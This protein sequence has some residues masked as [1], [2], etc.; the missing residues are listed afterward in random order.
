M[1]GVALFG[2]VLAADANLP[3]GY[4]GAMGYVVPVLLGLWVRSTAYPLAVAVAAS[5]AAVGV[6]LGAAPPAGVA[7]WLV[8]LNRGTALVAIWASA[9]V[10]VAYR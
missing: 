5:V 10:V 3:P 9:A 4:A 6:R 8:W 2:L 1:W 7:L